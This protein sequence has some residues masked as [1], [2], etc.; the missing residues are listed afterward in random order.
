M[1]L[2]SGIDVSRGVLQC[3]RMSFR[4]SLLQSISHVRPALSLPC[5][6]FCVVQAHHV[7]YVLKHTYSVS[8]TRCKHFGGRGFASL[9]PCCPAIMSVIHDAPEPH[10]VFL[11]HL[12]AVRTASRVWYWSRPWAH[13]YW[14]LWPDLNYPDSVYLVPIFLP[15]TWWSQ[16]SGQMD[17]S[18]RESRAVVLR[19]VFQRVLPSAYSGTK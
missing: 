12:L 6:A 8:P 16:I 7:C 15:H 13:M 2:L 4:K 14:G 17:W 9:Y 11:A 1:S 19:Q 10:C 3:C 18:W 5:S